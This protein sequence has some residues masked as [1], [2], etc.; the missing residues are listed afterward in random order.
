MDKLIYGTTLFIKKEIIE[1]IYNTN[2]IIQTALFECYVYKDTITKADIIAI[3]YPN[4]NEDKDDT[5]LYTRIHSSCITSEMIGSM[6]CDCVQ[7]LHGAIKYIAENKNGILFY[8]IQEGRGCGYIGKSRACQMVQY[9][10]I[11]GDNTLTTFEAYK[12]LGMKPEYRSYHNIREILYLLGMENN[13][14]TLLTNN[15]DKINGLK[16]LGINIHNTT[17]IE[18]TPNPFN[19]SYLVSKEAYGHK[20]SKLGNNDNNPYHMPHTPIKP[21]DIYKIKDPRYLHISS[22]YLPINNNIRQSRYLVDKNLNEPYWMNMN[23]YYDMELGHEFI[24]LNYNNFQNNNILYIHPENIINRLPL[25]NN[26]QY[27]KYKENINNI[28]TNNGGSIILYYKPN[29]GLTKTEEYDTLLYKSA[30]NLFNIITLVDNSSIL[31]R[32]DYILNK[33]YSND[34]IG[35]ANNQNYKTIFNKDTYI[36]SGMGSSIYHAKYL[37]KLLNNVGKMSYFINFE[38]LDNTYK[39]I[40]IISQGINPSILKY[41]LNNTIELL[42]CGNKLSVEKNEK[43]SHIKKI[44]FE[45]DE[46]DN[47][48]TRITGTYTCFELLDNLFEIQNEPIKNPDYNIIINNKF[49]YYILYDNEPWIG[50]IGNLLKELYNIDI[51]YSGNY[52]EFVHGTYQSSLYNKNNIYLYFGFNENIHKL[53]RNYY[54]KNVQYFFI[55]ENT[56]CNLIKIIYNN[57]KNNNN[58]LINQYNWF[59]KNNQ[60]IIYNDE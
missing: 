36:V 42:I 56:I 37:V 11:L 17:S 49:K 15:P 31:F 39:N 19:K 55:E 1:L 2:P 53:L 33:S 12:Q 4:N 27:N 58:F 45:G 47:T 20:L 25:V 35:D 26:E 32:I 6:D 9:N 38:E 23:L 18:F 10:E 59:G 51:L 34:V 30:I 50:I 16:N 5:T 48:L 24:I 41:I 40:I 52:K 21:F 46:P 13:K 44:F 54:T 28:I 57:I 60:G 14:F 8:L 3:K 29:F 22:Y 43:I 7:Q